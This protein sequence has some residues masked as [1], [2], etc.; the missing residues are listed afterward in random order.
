MVKVYKCFTQ[1]KKKTNGEKKNQFTPSIRL[2]SGTRAERARSVR[3]RLQQQS[4]R[5][6]TVLHS[7][8]PPFPPSTRMRLRHLSVDPTPLTFPFHSFHSDAG[9]A[10]RGA[11]PLCIAARAAD[12]PPS[13]PFPVVAAP[14]FISTRL[15]ADPRGLPSALRPNRWVTQPNQAAV[16][17]SSGRRQQPALACGF[18]PPPTRRRP[19]PALA[20]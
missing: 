19:Q 6:G 3:P 17:L 20:A 2:S 16:G 14:A 10:R 4:A 12:P 5:A 18:P 11:A 9:A 1:V 7:T 15:A 13:S 8:D